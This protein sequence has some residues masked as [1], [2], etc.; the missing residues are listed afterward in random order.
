MAKKKGE[1]ESRYSGLRPFKPGQSGNPS[2]RPKGSKNKSTKALKEFFRELTDSPEY[3][4]ELRQRLLDGK[5]HPAIEKYL[6]E[7]N[8]GPVPKQINLNAGPTLVEL[9]TGIDKGTGKGG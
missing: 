6:L 5:L 3:R 7:H 4:A 2:G 1:L 8:A 9:L